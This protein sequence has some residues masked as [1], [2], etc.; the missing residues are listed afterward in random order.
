M[1]FRNATIDTYFQLSKQEAKH[2]P[3]LIIWPETA[4]RFI[5]GIMRS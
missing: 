4:V 2:H 1:E 3:D 5:S